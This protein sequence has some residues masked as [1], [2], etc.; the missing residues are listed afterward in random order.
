MKLLDVIIV[1]LVSSS[2]F[3]AAFAGIKTCQSVKREAALCR[4]KTCAD[5]FVYES[6]R[7]T[8]KGKGFSDL[9]HWQVTCRALLKLDYIGWCNSEDFMIDEVPETG[10]LMYGRWIGNNCEGEVYC[11]EQ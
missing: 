7:N 8:C 11:R 9:N 10:K 1:F 4:E 2:L 3:L 5:R 6:F